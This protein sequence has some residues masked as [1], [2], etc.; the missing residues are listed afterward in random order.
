MMLWSRPGHDRHSARTQSLEE[1]G[2]FVRY[3]LTSS[4]KISVETKDE[5]KARRLKSP[6]AVDAFAMTF[7]VGDHSG[8][9]HLP[10]QASDSDYD[11]IAAF[12][13]Y[14]QQTHAGSQQRG[15]FVGDGWAPRWVDRDDEQQQAYGI[16]EERQL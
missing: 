12:D 3:K 10:A 7:F 1:P 8:W 6:N 9:R 14:M 2:R 5:M 4:G 15:R 16:E 13:Q 11:A